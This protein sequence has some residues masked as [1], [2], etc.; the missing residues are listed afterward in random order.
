MST[1]IDSNVFNNLSNHLINNIKIINV[2]GYKVTEVLI[3]IKDDKCYGFGQNNWGVLGLGH[4]IQVK[5]PKII[6]ELCNKQ[7]KSFANGLYHV[8]AL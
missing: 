7:I 1:Y 6:E 3:V 2:F 5:E 8:M 4:D